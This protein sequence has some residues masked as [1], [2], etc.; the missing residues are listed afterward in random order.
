MADYILKSEVTEHISNRQTAKILYLQ[1][2][3][4]QAQDQ[5]KD[6]NYMLQ[7]NREALRLSI[8]EKQDQGC[9]PDFPN[10]NTKENAI[11][12]YFIEENKRLSSKIDSLTKERN[13]SQSRVS[14]FFKFII[15]LFHEKRHSLIYKLQKNLIIG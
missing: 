14:D 10:T 3:L 15:I 8:Q 4:A 9:S 5:I 13:L 11:N 12:S 7:L 6:L 1:Q 2:E